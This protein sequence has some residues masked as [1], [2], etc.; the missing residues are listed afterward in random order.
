MRD[1]WNRD[2][3]KWQDLPLKEKVDMLRK[4]YCT[5]PCGQSSSTL[6]T[7]SALNSV[8]L[9]VIEILSNISCLPDRNGECLVCDNFLD[10]C[11][12]KG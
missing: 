4:Y 8:L 5:G 12:L 2:P 7:R 11:P 10:N 9:D 1:L 3:L 6:G